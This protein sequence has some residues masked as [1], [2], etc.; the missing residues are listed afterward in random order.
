MSIPV[1]RELYSVRDEL[2]KDLTGTLRAVA[3]D[4]YQVV[5]FYAPYYSW[6]ADYAK[7]ARKLMDSLENRSQL[8]PQWR[9]ASR[10]H[11]AADSVA[12]RHS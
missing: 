2:A 7:T 11:A 5:E 12:P 3:R 6:T 4:G 9:V 10:V 8:D 1:G